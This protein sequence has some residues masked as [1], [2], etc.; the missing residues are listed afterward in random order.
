MTKAEEAYV[1]TLNL[2]GSDFE[3]PKIQ[4]MIDTEHALADPTFAEKLR[5]RRLTAVS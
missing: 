2:F 5:A 4:E 3:P 1:T